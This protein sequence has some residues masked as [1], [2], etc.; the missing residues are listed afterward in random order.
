ML[1]YY[2]NGNFRPVVMTQLEWQFQ[3]CGYDT[4]SI[5]ARL[6][7][8]D[9]AEAPRL[10]L[11]TCSFQFRRFISEYNRIVK[12]IHKHRLALIYITAQHSFT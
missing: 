2:L 1:F 10:F 3:A 11:F 8:T 6:K 7:S 4:T 9:F 5:A 12:H